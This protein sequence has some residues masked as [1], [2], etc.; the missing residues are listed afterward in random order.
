MIQRGDA[1]AP[2]W[3]RT[4]LS[5]HDVVKIIIITAAARLFKPSN[6]GTRARL[7]ALDDERRSVHENVPI[8]PENPRRVKRAIGNAEM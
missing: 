7:S 5:I 1:L 6:D 3:N 2:R 4:R 8:R